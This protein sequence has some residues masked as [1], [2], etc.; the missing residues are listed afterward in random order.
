MQT[1][2]DIHEPRGRYGTAEPNTHSNTGNDSDAGHQYRVDA[3][4][5]TAAPVA[6]IGAGSMG[7]TLA[8]RVAAKGRTCHLFA[9]AAD[10]RTQ[11]EKQRR[12]WLF[13]DVALAPTLEISRDMASAVARAQLVI[14]A[15]PS[16]LFRGVAMALAPHLRRE[17]VVLSA[18]K[19]LDPHT[20]QRMSEV[21][22]QVTPAGA[23]GAISGPN[24]TSE[25]MR[26]QPTTIVVAS[27]STTALQLAA[28]ALQGPRLAVHGNR[29][30]IGVE[31]IGAL[32]NVVA[33]AAGMGKGLG[34]GV[35]ACAVL[36]ARGLA[37]IRHL[38]TALGAQPLTFAGLSGISD[39]YLTCTSPDSLNRRTGIELGRGRALADI[40]AEL[41]ERPE[42]IHS[43]MACH[44][45]AKR[46]DMRLPIAATTHG[47]LR[48]WFEASALE[49]A[50]LHPSISIEVD[51][52]PLTI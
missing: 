11:L 48:G 47:I 26:E 35:N 17:H 30:L 13:P 5:A 20:Y 29:D 38:A 32:K 4:C 16:A 15:V 24:I 23:V 37:E 34:L 40:L 33:M 39:L 9:L 31:L 43:V 19:G 28:Q 25:I 36:L 41:P 50:I 46:L 8:Q 14:V 22:R 12:H 44:E 49:R 3:A 1:F 7:I 21:L 51:S 6:V 27:R 18:T 10:K 52:E 2:D 45:L 42:G